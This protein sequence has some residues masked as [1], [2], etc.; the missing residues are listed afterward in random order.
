ML[1]LLRVLIWSTLA[2]DSK[3]QQQSSLVPQNNASP[4]VFCRSQGLLQFDQPHRPHSTPGGLPVCPQF[5]CSCCS[6]QHTLSILRLLAPAL[7]D[8]DA[9]NDGGVHGNSSSRNHASPDNSSSS[10][11]SSSPDDTLSPG[12]ADEPPDPDSSSGSSSSKETGSRGTGSSGWAGL[13][14]ACAEL[15]TLL[16]CRVCDPLVGV[17]LKPA[18]CH[19]TCQAWYRAC[20]PHFFTFDPR[21]D[22]LAP[23]PAS[24][25]GPGALPC[26]RLKDMSNKLNDETLQWYL[27]DRYFDVDE[28]EQKLRRM[29]AWRED[30]QPDHITA[31]QVAKEASSG[32]AY[33]HSHLDVYGRPAIV[34]RTR[35]HVC[36]VCVLY[37]GQYPINDS[38]RLA[39]FLIDQAI[40]QAQ[41]AGG[42]QILGIFDLRD[43]QVEA[44][45]EYYP[46]RVA[47]VLFVEAPWMFQPAWAAIQP[48]MRKYAALVGD[49]LNPDAW[50]WHSALGSSS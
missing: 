18:V 14:K 41:A 33:V 46:R 35:L 40:A 23:C 1:V 50:R 26:S 37:A 8:L 21:S 13:S 12:V 22:Q 47:Q 31:S 30:F 24:G 15:T 42:E 49:I 19:S 48:L 43:F 38:K 7:S 45:F 36:D 20:S 4:R 25:P 39:V 29:L 28:A 10:S 17:G 44:F 6:R 9:S 27:R 16:A 32:K 2:V 34:I 11:S 3:A 5:S